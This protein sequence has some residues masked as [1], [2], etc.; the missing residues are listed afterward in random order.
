LFLFSDALRNVRVANSEKRK[1]F[2]N[3]GASR[4]PEFFCHFPMAGASSFL[5]TFFYETSMCYKLHTMEKLSH[6]SSIRP[7]KNNLFPD[8][9]KS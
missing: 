9:E 2:K 8:E 7:L 6:A 1:R 4:I 5:P 3:L